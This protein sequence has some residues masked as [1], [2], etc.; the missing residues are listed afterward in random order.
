MEGSRIYRI[1]IGADHHTS[2]LVRALNEGGW[3]LENDDDDTTLAEVL[4]VCDTFLADEM[5]QYA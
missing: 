4:M 1:E 3:V 2:S 5:R